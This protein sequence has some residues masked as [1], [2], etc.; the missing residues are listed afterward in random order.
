MNLYYYVDPI[1]N[2]IVEGIVLSVSGKDCTLTPFLFRRRAHPSKK[3]QQATATMATSG[4]S[5]K[6][7]E[8]TSEIKPP[9]PY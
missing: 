2:L 6:H 7:E 5:K 3:K 4:W 8:A 9:R 1:Q